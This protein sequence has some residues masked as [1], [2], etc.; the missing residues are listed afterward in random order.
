LTSR[1]SPPNIAKLATN[2]TIAATIL[3]ISDSKTTDEADASWAKANRRIPAKRRSQGFCKIPPLYM[4]IKRQAKTAPNRRITE[5][6]SL[7]K[8]KATS[9]V[10]ASNESSPHNTN[11][12]NIMKLTA[13]RSFRISDLVEENMPLF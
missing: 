4:E 8:T 9:N 12:A 13:E 11:H 3:S 6:T 7:P 5:A 10:S 2:E 1:K